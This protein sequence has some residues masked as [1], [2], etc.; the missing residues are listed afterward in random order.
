MDKLLQ[1]LAWVAVDFKLGKDI[2]VRE[3]EEK[4]SIPLAILHIAA[5]AIVFAG[6]LILAFL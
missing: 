4:H 1:L 5:A 2:E 3:K 6:F